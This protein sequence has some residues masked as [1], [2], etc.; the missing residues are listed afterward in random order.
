MNNYEKKIYWSAIE[1]AQALPKER[2]IY[3]EG[4]NYKYALDGKNRVA[5]HNGFQWENVGFPLD[6]S[7][8]FYSLHPLDK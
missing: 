2:Y 8:V 5:R 3:E 7:H 1:A 4:T 6:N